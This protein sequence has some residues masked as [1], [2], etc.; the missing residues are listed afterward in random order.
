MKL[1]VQISGAEVLSSAIRRVMQ[2]SEWNDTVSEDYK[3]GFNDF[4]EALLK[5]CDFWEDD[6]R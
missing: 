4:A 3:R 1:S 2:E 6:R 5:V